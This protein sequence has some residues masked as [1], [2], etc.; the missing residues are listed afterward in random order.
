MEKALYILDYELDVEYRNFVKADGRIS[1]E[2]ETYEEAC[3]K[4]LKRL[5][6]SKGEVSQWESRGMY[7]GSQVKHNYKH[8]FNLVDCFDQKHATYIPSSQEINVNNSNTNT[9]MSVAAARG[10]LF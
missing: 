10:G 6:K 1:V 2:A 3:E 9:S 7:G 4:A 5:P 8:V